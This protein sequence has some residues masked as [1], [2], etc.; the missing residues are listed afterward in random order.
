M[1]N[2]FQ[3]SLDQIVGEYN[4]F[5]MEELIKTATPEQLLEHQLSITEA[6]MEIYYL[7]HYDLA[8]NR[9]AEENQVDLMDDLLGILESVEK[10]D[11]SIIY[12]E[13]RAS[14]YNLLAEIQTETSQKLIAFQHAIDTY[15]TAI[16]YPEHLALQA[17]LANTLL[18]KAALENIFDKSLFDEMLQLFN[19]AYTEYSEKVM[20]IFLYTSFDILKYPFD[21][22]DQ[23]HAAFI[24]Q[25][26]NSTFA[27]AKKDPLI[28]LNW[29]N[30][31]T[32]IL[33]NDY[34]PI[35][36]SFYQE[37]N[38]FILGLLTHITHHY[39]D[40]QDVLN[41]LGHEFEKAAN[42]ISDNPSQKLEFYTNAL[43][44]FLKG[45]EINSWAWTFPVYATNVLTK[46]AEI[47]AETNQPT[48]VTEAFEHGRVVF[49][50][51][52]EPNFTLYLNW[53]RFLI[54]YARLASNFKDTYVLR[55]AEEKLLLAKTLGENYYDQPFLSLAKVAL[56]LGEVEKCI[57]ILTECK[58]VF[59]TDYAVYSLSKVTEDADFK[60]ILDHELF[61]N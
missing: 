4:V 22:K 52:H 54:E 37:V 46:M 47:Y 45:Q 36:T 56:K 14:C 35:S 51:M 9:I 8:C 15:R 11:P 33:D 26:N 23:K 17:S 30:Q 16:K 59:T 40:S 39:T 58:T 44:Y 1:E 6:Y 31:L 38:T 61:K 43:N 7:F 20:H 49:A 55:E 10:L 50:T 53:G 27:Y 28:Y 34:Y 3:D 32:R 57:E 29:A 5:A 18:D 19:M 12:Y 48:K 24:S 60:D 21:R 42:R 2:T 25:F 13:E 41:E